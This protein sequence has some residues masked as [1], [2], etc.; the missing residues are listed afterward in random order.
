[1][2]AENLRKAEVCGETTNNHGKALEN[3]PIV[4]KSAC[5]CQSKCESRARC[6]GW[7]YSS[8]KFTKGKKNC[9]L[10]KRWGKPVDNCGKDCQS[11]PKAEVCG[12]TTNNNGKV[13]ENMPIVSKSACDCQSKCESR[14]RCQ[15]W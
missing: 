8:G 7:T 13:L 10:R 5:D 2:Q 15:G 1:M 9:W 6:Q 14:A 11:A 4:S 3:M 12:E